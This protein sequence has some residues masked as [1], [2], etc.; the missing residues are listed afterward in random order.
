MSDPAACGWG[1][2]RQRRPGTIENL[3]GTRA[4]TTP[5]GAFLAINRRSRPAD[6]ELSRGTRLFE[7]RGIPIRRQIVTS[8]PLEI[9]EGI[10]SCAGMIDRVILG[11]GD[12]TMNHS[13]ETILKSGLPLGILPLGTA[14]DLARTLEIPLSV[15]EAFLVI[16]EGRVQWIDLGRV[17]GRFFFNVAHIGLGARVTGKVGSETKKRWGSLA[18]LRE[19]VA[20]TRESRPFRT[21]VRC[22][23]RRDSFRSIHIAVGNGRHYGGGMT[24]SADAEIDDGVLH[25]YVVKPRPF[26]QVLLGFSAFRK[27]KAQ[28]EWIH[29]M[30]GKQIAVHTGGSLPVTVDGEPATRT[31][32]FFEVVPSILPVF[33]PGHR[34]A[35]RSRGGL[36]S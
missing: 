17:N 34:A 14:N 24:V 2:T 6:E 29:Y 9:A 1:A 19:V 16:A 35:A 8:D 32:A 12:G 5:K 27:G 28:G 18:Y 36:E 31:P 15:E 7:E 3:V 21:T 11:G 20:A 26:A 30:Q 13:V 25:L 33:V 22:D 4:T 10:R 23:G